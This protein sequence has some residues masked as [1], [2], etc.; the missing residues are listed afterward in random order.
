MGDIPSSFLFDRDNS[1]ILSKKVQ[2]N[3]SPVLR[4]S[5]RIGLTTCH[6]SLVILFFVTAFQTSF[7]FMYFSGLRL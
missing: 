6:Q 1:D 5:S 7:R 2:Q 4:Y 3:I